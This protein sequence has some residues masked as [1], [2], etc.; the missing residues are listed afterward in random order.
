MVNIESV[1]VVKPGAAGVRLIA[2]VLE[3]NAAILRMNEALLKGI[4]APMVIVKEGKPS[5]GGDA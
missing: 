5:K 2:R 4:A 1:K 3:Q